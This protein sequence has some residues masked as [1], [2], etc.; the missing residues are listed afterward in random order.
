MWKLLIAT[1]LIYRSNFL[2]PKSCGRHFLNG[3]YAL[4][5]NPQFEKCSMRNEYKFS[6]VCLKPQVL[7]GKTTLWNNP[8]AYWL[9]VC[10]KKSLGSLLTTPE[11][12]GLPPNTFGFYNVHTKCKTIFEVHDFKV[13][14]HVVVNISPTTN[15]AV[16]LFIKIFMF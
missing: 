14:A 4:P 13:M 5:T 7:G 10:I 2:P 11:W 16:W 6:Q 8:L 12:V 3:Q 1:Q 9:Q 15:S